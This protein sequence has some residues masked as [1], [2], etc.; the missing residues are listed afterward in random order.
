MHGRAMLRRTTLPDPPIITWLSAGLRIGTACATTG[1][2]VLNQSSAL[3]HMLLA[4]LAAR[5]KNQRK[6]THVHT[7][8]FSTKA[9]KHASG[10]YL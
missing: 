8:K 4:K 6:R 10:G 9:R 7:P 5:V 1:S 2:C 3:A